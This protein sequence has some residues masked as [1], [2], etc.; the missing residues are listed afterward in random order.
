MK[1]PTAKDFFGDDRD[2]YTK[3]VKKRDWHYC[4]RCSNKTIDRFNRICTSCKGRVLFQGDDGNL[5]NANMDYWYIW[6]RPVMGIE[7]YYAKSY[8]DDKINELKY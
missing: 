8:F 1:T 6:L 5:L 2:Q 4:P 3:I 7:G